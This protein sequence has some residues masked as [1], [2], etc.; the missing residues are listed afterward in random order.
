[1]KVLMI[2]QLI[3][4][5]STILIV[6][7][8]TAADTATENPS[9]KILPLPLDEVRIFAEVLNRIRSSYVE[10]VDDKTLLENAIKG[11]LAG[12]DPHSTY[13]VEDEFDSLQETTTGEFGGLGV[14]VVSEDGYIKV[15]TPVDGS[16]ADQ[17]GV[18]A[19]DLIIQLD[20]T[21]ARDITTGDTVNIMRG[22]PGTP[23]VLTIIREGIDQPFEITVIR[24]IIASR[25]IRTRT[26]DS[27]YAYIRIS[28][29]SAKTGDEVRGAVEKFNENGKMEGFILDLRNNPGGVLQASVGVVDAFV[30]EGLILYTEGRIENSEMRFEATPY[31][32]SQG[33]PLI[34]LIN[35][36]SASASEIV[37][38]SL[39]DHN[40]AIIMGTKS[41]GKGSVQ[42]VLPLT[43][44]RALKLT[45]ALYFTPSGRSIQ[46]LGVTPDIIVDRGRVTSIPV[47][48]ATYR[49]ED[50]ANHLGNASGETSPAIPEPSE[51]EL[52]EVIV[53]DYQLNEALNVLKGMKVLRQ[54]E[55]QAFASADLDEPVVE[56][57]SIEADTVSDQ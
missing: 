47:S 55:S 20:G 5:L 18:L 28:E 50:L 44:D 40:R 9:E 34:V 33:V 56:E 4:A 53:S 35:E 21:P 6:F 43:N 31:N 37:A 26:L 54:I 22:E 32:P 52:G 27:D 11:M 49:E 16:P 42:T 38:G 51:D 45:T 1:M 7:P 48:L 15:V 12:I 17:A 3:L 39:Q 30:S 46:A 8:A 41:F 14:E 23:I 29:F 19:G 2:K 24:D 10:P 13:L 57:S 25:S 36:G